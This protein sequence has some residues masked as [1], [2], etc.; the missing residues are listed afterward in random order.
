MVPFSALE[1]EDGSSRLDE[2][3]SPDADPEGALQRVEDRAM[4]DHLIGRLPPVFREV[5]V[6]RELEE[7]SYRE[8]AAIAQIPIGTV[9]SRL[10]RARQLLLDYGEELARGEQGRAV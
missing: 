3:A 9:M 8:I 10:A 4:V 7:L 1:R 5:L 2:L 6:L